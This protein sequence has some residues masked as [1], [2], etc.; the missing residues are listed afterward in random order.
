MP[1]FWL[2]LHKVD[3]VWQWPAN[4]RAAGQT[5]GTGDWTG[6]EP[7][8]APAL[9]G[10]MYKNGLQYGVGDNKASDVARALCHVWYPR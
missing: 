9:G 8:N 3:G 4:Q 2:G 7:N 5:A 1:L 6:I 10:T